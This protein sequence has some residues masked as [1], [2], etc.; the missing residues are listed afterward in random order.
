[1]SLCHK[2]TSS[3]FL[4]N[5]HVTRTFIVRARLGTLTGRVEGFPFQWSLDDLTQN[6]TLRELQCLSVGLSDSEI[7]ASGKSLI[8]IWCPEHVIL[9]SYTW[10]A[11]P[12]D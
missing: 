5:N 7:F 2:Y 4:L 10:W 8:H 11:V 6:W 3:S 9:G 1:M 12:W